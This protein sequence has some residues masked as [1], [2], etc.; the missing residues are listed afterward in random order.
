MKK[1]T[2]IKPLTST[3]I[4]ELMNIKTGEKK[5]GRIMFGN[6]SVG[7]STGMLFKGN[8]AYYWEKPICFFK[9]ANENIEEKLIFLNSS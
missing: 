1:I 5:S 2:E 4:K 7:L 9:R 8:N 3:Q 6:Q